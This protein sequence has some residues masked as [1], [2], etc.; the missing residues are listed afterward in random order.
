MMETDLAG[1]L[2]GLFHEVGA[3]HHQAYIETDGADPEWPLWYADY[4]RERLGELLD[5]SFTKS[6]LVHMLVLVANE[7]PLVAPGAN[8]ARYYAKKFIALYT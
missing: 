1:Q 7:Q 2:E 4:L 5:A 8:W 3:A 6:E